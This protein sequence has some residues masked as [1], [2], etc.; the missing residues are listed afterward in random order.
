MNITLNNTEIEEALVEHIATKGLS[1]TGKHIEVHLTAG[2]GPNGHSATIEILDA[3]AS[4]VTAE[5]V[6]QDDAEPA[7]SRV[8]FD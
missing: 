5:D 3:K 8:A 1:V 6:T 2:R 7:D 4:P